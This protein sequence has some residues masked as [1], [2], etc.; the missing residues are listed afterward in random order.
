[1]RS[2]VVVVVVVV[3]ESDGGGAAAA[4]S[5]SSAPVAPASAPASSAA[6]LVRLARLARLA[7]LR[8]R[9]LLAWLLVE[10][11][12]R[13][14]GLLLRGREAGE[15]GAV[16]ELLQ[17][18]GLA[19]LELESVRGGGR[20]LVVGAAPDRTPRRPVGFAALREEEGPAQGPLVETPRCAAM[21]WR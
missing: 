17:V 16:D 11:V 4:P 10:A 12:A 2:F 3:C 1:M 20:C 6:W 14:A 19:G 15:L 7:R 13:E 5:T 8:A 18:E 9:P 21:G